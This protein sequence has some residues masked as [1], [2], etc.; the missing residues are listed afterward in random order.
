MDNFQSCAICLFQPLLYNNC[1]ITTWTLETSFFL[2]EYTGCPNFHETSIG[3]NRILLSI[4]LQQFL[5]YTDDKNMHLLGGIIIS[6]C[7]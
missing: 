4:Y 2:L 6:K 3:E 1:S 5:T 7:R